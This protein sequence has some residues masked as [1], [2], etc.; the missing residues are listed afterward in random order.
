MIALH[1]EV[2]FN[3]SN[4]KYFD[5][6]GNEVIMHIESKRVNSFQITN[7]FDNTEKIDI[8]FSQWED[9]QGFSFPMQ[10]QIIQGGKKEYFFKFYEVKVDAPSF[11]KIL[12]L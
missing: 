10:V 1:P 3:Y 6:I 4:G 5:A 11:N 12:L 8:Y 9:V 2:V 7:P